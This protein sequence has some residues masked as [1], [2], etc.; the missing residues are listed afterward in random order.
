MTTPA[1]L[2]H[3]QPLIT[4]VQFTCSQLHARLSSSLQHSTPQ[5]ALTCS[6]LNNPFAASSAC[7]VHRHVTHTH[8]NTPHVGSILMQTHTCLKLLELASNAAHLPGREAGRLARARA[9]AGKP[10]RRRLFPAASWVERRRPDQAAPATPEHMV[11]HVRVQRAT[12]LLAAA[13]LTCKLL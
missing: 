1:K 13:P 5:L 4:T 12:Q 10:L 6:P 11:R 9:H 8:T 3:L 7:T 2:L